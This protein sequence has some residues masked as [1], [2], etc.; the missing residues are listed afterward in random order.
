MSSVPG[1]FRSLEIKLRSRVTGHRSLM[2]DWL[3][4]NWG[5]LALTLVGGAYFCF[6][7]VLARERRAS[8]NV[9][10][11]PEKDC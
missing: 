2:L 5:W 8:P 9:R 3:L 10:R 1:T 7:V 4:K 11:R 6:Y